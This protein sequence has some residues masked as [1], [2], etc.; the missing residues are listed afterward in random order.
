MLLKENFINFASFH[1]KVQK[2]YSFSPY[3]LEN[4]YVVV[5]NHKKFWWAVKLSI[6]AAFVLQLWIQIFQNPESEP[7]AT[8][9]ISVLFAEIWSYLLFQDTLTFQRTEEISRGFNYFVQFEHHNLSSWTTSNGMKN[10]DRKLFT[11]MLFATVTCGPIS[12]PLYALL[13][14]FDPCNS[15]TFGWTLLPECF[16]EVEDV[17]WTNKSRFIL[18]STIIFTCWVLLGESRFKSE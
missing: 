12:V 10:W 14:W 4:N 11:T 9:S 5:H 2:F 18:E 17:E 1:L 13:R 15:A 16:N 6:F 3:A 8:T 7:L